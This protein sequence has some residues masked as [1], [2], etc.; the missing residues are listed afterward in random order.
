MGVD[1]PTLGSFSLGPAQFSYYNGKNPH[2]M[3]ESFLIL[4]CM[5]ATRRR[6]HSPAPSADATDIC[7]TTYIILVGS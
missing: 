6:L 5:Q 1:T 4:I 7:D 2:E 3:K